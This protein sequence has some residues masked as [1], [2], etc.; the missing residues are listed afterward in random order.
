LPGA[1]KLPGAGYLY[2]H[3]YPGHFIQQEY[4]PKELRFRQYYYPSDQ[5]AEIQIKE[6]LERWWGNAKKPKSG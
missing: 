6:R 2:G 3:D 1:I 4:L 5:G